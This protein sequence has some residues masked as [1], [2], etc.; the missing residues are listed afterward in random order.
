LVKT[1]ANFP[2]NS[3]QGVLIIEFLSVANFCRFYFC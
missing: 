1:E 3:N 2:K